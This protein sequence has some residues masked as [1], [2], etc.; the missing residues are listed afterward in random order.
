M[1]MLLRPWLW[2]FPVGLALVAGGCGAP[3]RPEGDVG[4]MPVTFVIQADEAFFSRMS[5]HTV[6]SSSGIGVGLGGGGGGGGMGVG[7]G[8][9]IGYHSTTA[10]LLGGAHPGEA[11]SFRRRLGWG[12]TC[13]TVPLN[14]GRH[15]V[16]TA[17]AEGGRTGWETIGEFTVA[18]PA[19]DEVEVTLD[20]SGSKISVH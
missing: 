15:I 7:L 9:G 16:L 10:S 17:Q 3:A 19:A 8:L 14:V 4:G 20:A 13:F 11:G 1:K 2:V 6:T 12:T 18:N 5:D